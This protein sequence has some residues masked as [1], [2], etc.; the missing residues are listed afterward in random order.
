M[1]YKKVNYTLLASK[2]VMLV[3]KFGRPYRLRQVVYDIERKQDIR[4]DLGMLKQNL[5]DYIDERHI[6]KVD[7][8]RFGNEI[9]IMIV[10]DW[11][12]PNAT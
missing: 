12:K 9:R 7:V 4:V 1:K 5:G 11:V 2:I 3:T 6:E 10:E 8:D